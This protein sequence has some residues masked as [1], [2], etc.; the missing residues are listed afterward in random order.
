[1]LPA[2]RQRWHSCSSIHSCNF[3]VAVVNIFVLLYNCWV[4]RK[5]LFA[6]LQG[7][8]TFRG[9]MIDM[10]LLRQAKNIVHLQQIM[11][12]SDSVDTG[13]SKTWKMLCAD[14]CFLV[15][16]Q[17]VHKK[18]A[19][20]FLVVTFVQLFD[21]YYFLYMNYADSHQL[22]NQINHHIWATLTM[23]WRSCD[24]VLLLITK[25]PNW[26]S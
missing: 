16:V 1:V 5:L 9:N 12:A 24:V 18:E 19:S 15:F 25:M 2:T 4:I 17:R 7:A 14:V 8:F 13:Q 20:S 10:P 21:I 11:S 22:N 3:V 23:W 26:M 6:C